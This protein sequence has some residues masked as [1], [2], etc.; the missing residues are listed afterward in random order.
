MQNY[1]K[2]NDTSK[3][4]VI[5]HLENHRMITTKPGLVRSLKFYYKDNVP[6][7]DAGYTVFDS[8]PTSFVVNSKLETHDS[9][10]FVKRFTDLTKPKHPLKEKMPAK[11]CAKNLWLVKPANENQG[12]GI[13]ILDNVNEIMRFLESSIKFSYWVIQK[14]IE[15]P[16]LYKNRKFDVRVWAFAMSNLDFYFYE[17]GY[18]RTS[19]GEYSFDNV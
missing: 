7:V 14:Y 8:T 18:L 16:L 5:N 2:K 17:D 1:I 19:S 13:K 15:K 10:Q 12:K 9:H 3:E 4:V 6:F 11:H